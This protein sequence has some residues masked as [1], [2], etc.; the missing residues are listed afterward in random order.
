MADDGSTYVASGTQSQAD[1]Y[2]IV[3]SSKSGDISKVTVYMRARKGSAGNSPELKIRVK[4]GSTTSDSSAKSLTTS[5]ANYS[6]DWTTDPNT[7]S[8]WTWS[9]ID[10]LQIG[11]SYYTEDGSVYVTQMWAVVEYEGST[12]RVMLFG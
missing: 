3:N 9:A 2:N 6:N 11:V 7:S 10:S 1:L 4:S 12:A 8:A 5:Y